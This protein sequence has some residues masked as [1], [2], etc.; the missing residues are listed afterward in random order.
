M[1]SKPSIP[2]TNVQQEILKVFSISLN[3]NELQ[4]FKKNITQFLLQK[5]RNEADVMWNQKG[6][7][8]ETIKNWLNLNQ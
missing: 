6:Y 4:D 7:N 1:Q 2:L 3:E 8:N 5:I